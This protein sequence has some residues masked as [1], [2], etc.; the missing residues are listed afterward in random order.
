MSSD[1]NRKNLTGDSL[2]ATPIVSSTAHLK[3]ASKPLP[4]QETVYTTSK[5]ARPLVT[6]GT[7]AASSSSTVP[8]VALSSA[9]STVSDIAQRQDGSAN[10]DAESQPSANAPRDIRNGTESATSA[11]Q[12][13][14]Q[15][16]TTAA[17]AAVME[18][19]TAGNPPVPTPP[20][21]AAQVQP[22][23]TAQ[24]NAPP[25]QPEKIRISLRD[26][27]GNTVDYRVRMTSPLSPI[28]HNFARGLYFQRNEVRFHFDDLRVSD[29][30]TPISLG[31]IEGDTIDCFWSQLG[32]TLCLY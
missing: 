20:Q 26:M 5:A 17:S 8:S 4:H 10:N 13:E 6:V 21:Q 7:Q 32:G 11:L 24:Q 27:E 15:A 25:Q 3:S 14:I 31:L 9:T 18:T 12:N 30:S 22:E 1:T 16:A 28:L 29:K 23:N 2:N 19:Q